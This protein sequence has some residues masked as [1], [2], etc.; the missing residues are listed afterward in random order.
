MKRVLALLPVLFALQVGVSPALAWTWPV[1]G[2]V[3]R[4]FTFDP[5]D[6][7]AGGQ[8]RGIDVGAPSGAP[9]RA[10]AAG[11]VSFAGNVP[12]GGLTLAVRTADGYSV[13]LVHLGASGAAR[14][15]TSREGDAVGPVGPSGQPGLRAPEAG[16]AQPTA[17]DPAVESGAAAGNAGAPGSR[18]QRRNHQAAGKTFRHVGRPAQRVV[19]EAQR[20][21]HQPVTALAPPL[22]ERV[23][24]P[25][26]S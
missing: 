13:T 3:L 25:D 21:A 24:A 17:E 6:P 2:P 14:G 19:R 1:D 16:V 18:G 15:T 26:R 4:P 5:D 7:Y 22:V 10:P 12:G 11:T 8:H 20:A 9:V 23:N